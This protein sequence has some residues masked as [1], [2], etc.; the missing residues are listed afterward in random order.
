MERRVDLKILAAIL[1]KLT[2]QTIKHDTIDN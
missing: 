1:I 2:D